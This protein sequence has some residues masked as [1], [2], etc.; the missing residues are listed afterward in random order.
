MLF[1][2][3]KCKLSSNIDRMGIDNRSLVSRNLFICF[4]TTKFLFKSIDI[5]KSSDNNTIISSFISWSQKLL[6]SEALFLL[7][8]NLKIVYNFHSMF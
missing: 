7:I 1:F 8:A 4:G 3:T 2:N 6:D 5:I